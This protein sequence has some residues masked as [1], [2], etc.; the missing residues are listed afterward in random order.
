MILDKL[1][2]SWFQSRECNYHRQETDA[3]SCAQYYIIFIQF[4]VLLALL[5][6]VSV[7]C[8][9]FLCML[10]RRAIPILTPPHRSQKLASQYFW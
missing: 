10:K 6:K 7:T 9:E 1:N 2:V 4:G 3:G 5:G 8:A